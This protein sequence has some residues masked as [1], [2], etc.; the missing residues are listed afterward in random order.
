MTANYK[1]SHGYIRSILKKNWRTKLE[2]TNIES[3]EFDWL[4]TGLIIGVH[5]AFIIT[6]ILGFMGLIPDY[7]S[8]VNISSFFGLY[9]IT[10]WFGITLFFHRYLSHR[11]YEPTLPLLYILTVFGTL[12]FQGTWEKWSTEHMWHHKNSDTKLD[13]HDSTRGFWW[14]HLIW[15][16]FKRVPCEKEKNY[17]KP[18]L[19]IQFQL[20]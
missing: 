19:I 1:V 17:K 15:M 14:S 13:V 18:Y 7:F 6:F 2:Q 5:I 8:V 3:L 12:A 16:F 10:G 4:T 9:I 11:S 20:F